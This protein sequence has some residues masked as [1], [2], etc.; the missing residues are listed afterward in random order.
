[1]LRRIPLCRSPELCLQ[2]PPSA[3]SPLSSAVP[4]TGAP[5]WTTADGGR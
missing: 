2:P 3:V 4:V 1:E 5:S